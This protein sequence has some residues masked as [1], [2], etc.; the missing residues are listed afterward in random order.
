[1][2]EPR[3][4]SGGS[5]AGSERPSDSVG[6]QRKEM[7]LDTAGSTP[8]TTVA[9]QFSATVREGISEQRRWPP[10]VSWHCRVVGTVS[11]G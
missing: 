8:E 9:S 1:M 10:P 7:V 5:D 3:H 2:A 6:C 4:Q 11:E